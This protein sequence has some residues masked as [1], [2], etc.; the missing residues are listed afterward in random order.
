RDLERHIGKPRE[1]S[2]HVLTERL[3]TERAAGLR[4]RIRTSWCHR[5]EDRAGIATIPSIEVAVCDVER[6]DRAY[7]RAVLHVHRVPGFRVVLVS[8]SCL[9]IGAC[10]AENV[11]HRVVALVTGVLE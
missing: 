10:T 1:Q 5:L 8:V 11:P 9:L 3:A 7:T 4:I 2:V 6:T